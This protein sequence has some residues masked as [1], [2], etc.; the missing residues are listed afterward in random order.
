M[1]AE[2]TENICAREVLILRSREAAFRRMGRGL[3]RFETRED[4]LL[5]MRVC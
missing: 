3:M 1:T 4:A 5:T 2:I